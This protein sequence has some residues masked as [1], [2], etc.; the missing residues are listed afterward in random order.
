MQI[1]QRS[2]KEIGCLVQSQAFAP[3][4]HARVPGFPLAPTEAARFSEKPMD[5]SCAARGSGEQL[6]SVRGV[7]P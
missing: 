5:W 6:G 4:V 1:E 3:V 2:L 7:D